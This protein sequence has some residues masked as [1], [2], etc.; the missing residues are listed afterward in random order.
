MAEKFANT[1][2]F[3]GP[4]GVIFH[5]TYFSTAENLEKATPT[6]ADGEIVARAVLLNHLYSFTSVTVKSIDDPTKP[7]VQ[8]PIRLSGAVTDPLLAPANAKEAAV[9]SLVCTNGVL[10]SQRKIWMRGLD[11]TDVERDATTGIDKPS[12]IFLTELGVFLKAMAG[13]NPVNAVQP[14]QYGMLPRARATVTGPLF[15]RSLV[16]LGVPA[17][18]DIAVITTAVEHGFVAGNLVTINGA[19]QKKAPGLKGIFTV[20]DTTP[21]TFTIRYTANGIVLSLGGYAYKILRSNFLRINP[22][23]SAFAF[24]GSRDTKKLDTNSRGRR[25]ASRIRRL[26]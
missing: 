10:T 1:W 19:D 11:E 22:A 7:P 9:V 14:R 3:A 18:G 8:V 17:G 2:S 12:N 25:P 13:N 5:E 16:S 4:G 26:A 20:L 6:R 24:L 21:T 15:R 23:R